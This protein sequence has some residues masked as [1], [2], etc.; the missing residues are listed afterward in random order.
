MNTNRPWTPGPWE[1]H[2]PGRQFAD[3]PNHFEVQ[4]SPASIDTSV[5]PY[6]LPFRTIASVSWQ[7]SFEAERANARLI[8]AA[9]DLYEAAEAWHRVVAHET[10]SAMHGE[11]DVDREIWADLKARANDLTVAALAKARGE[12]VRNGC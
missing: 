11:D 10:L 4:A 5:N 8:A 12:E 9:P 1:T 7:G 2:V 6:P 3:W